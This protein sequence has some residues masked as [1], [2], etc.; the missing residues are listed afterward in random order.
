[1]ARP[2]DGQSLTVEDLQKILELHR[3]GMSSGN[4]G[5]KFNRDHSTIIYHLK[6]FRAIGVLET[7]TNVTMRVRNYKG[8]YIPPKVPGLYENQTYR[9]KEILEEPKNPGKSYKQYLKEASQKANDRDKHF[10]KA[11][12]RERACG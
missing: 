12:P 5:K 11:P 1:M 3:E 4:I 10:Y 2:I 9:Y 6:K 8:I 7:N